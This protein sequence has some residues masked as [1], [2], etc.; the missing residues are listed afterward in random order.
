MGITMA[1]A[2]SIAAACGSSAPARREPMAPAGPMEVAVAIASPGSRYCQRAADGCWD[3]T[4]IDFPAEVPAELTGC[5]GI[6]VRRGGEM[7]CAPTERLCCSSRDRTSR[8]RIRF[9][10]SCEAPPIAASCQPE[11]GDRDGD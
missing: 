5:A 10:D 9:G 8:E 7:R 6:G 11:C 4:G 2:L 3:C 1:L